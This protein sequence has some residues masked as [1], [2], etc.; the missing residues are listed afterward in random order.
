MGFVN[1]CT[2]CNNTRNGHWR[3]SVIGI[4]AGL[5]LWYTEGWEIKAGQSSNCMIFV[6][7]K[8]RVG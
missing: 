6:G 5:F 8:L 2:Q 1:K 4:Q 3:Y 7:M